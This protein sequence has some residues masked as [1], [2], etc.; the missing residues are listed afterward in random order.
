MDF[1]ARAGRP[2]RKSAPLIATL[3]EVDGHGEVQDLNFP[4]SDVPFSEMEG[5]V[6]SSPTRLSA[7]DPAEDHLSSKEAAVPGCDADEAVCDG[8]AE[9]SI[10][11]SF[12][13]RMRALNCRWNFPVARGPP[14]DSHFP[15]S[16]LLRAIAD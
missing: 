15:I 10:S 5:H 2:S 13:L 14:Y 9:I 3:E 4:M 8:L 12:H 7:G 16:R 6:G 11:R 1:C